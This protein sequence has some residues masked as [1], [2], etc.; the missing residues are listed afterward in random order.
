MQHS[1]GVVKSRLRKHV[2]EHSYAF[3][4]RWPV[5]QFPV[6]VYRSVDVRLWILTTKERVFLEP[7]KY[8]IVKYFDFILNACVLNLLEIDILSAQFEFCLAA[9]KQIVKSGDL[10]LNFS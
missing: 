6:Q 2:A 10:S 4:V 8:S 9:E 7:D 3:L 1:P 5:P